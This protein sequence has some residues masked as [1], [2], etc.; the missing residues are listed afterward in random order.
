[1]QASQRAIPCAFMRGGTSRGPFFLAADLPQDIATRDAVLLAVMGSPDPRQIDGLGGSDTLT[2]KVAIVS[3]SSMPGVDVDFLFAQVAVDKPLVDVSPNCGN[4]L[5][6]VGPFAIERGLVAIRGDSTPV[7]IHMVNSGNIATATVQTAG[8]RVVYDGDAR[9]AGVPGTS[10]PIN[11]AFRDT[12]GSAC[13]SLLPTGRTRDVFNGI[14]A[15]CIDNGMPVVVM[16]ADAFGKTGQETPQQLDADAEFKQRLEAVRLQA[17]ELM[18]L[19]DVRNKVVPKMTLISPAVNG[20]HISTRTFIP[21]RCHSAIGVLGAVSVA[22]ACL[23]PGSVAEGMTRL[24]QGADVE[25]SVE[26][27]SG[28]FTVALRTELHTGLHGSEMRFLSSGLLRTARM[29]LD[30]QVYVPHRVWP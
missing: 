11:I 10:A 21:H 15:T 22:S 29:L 28:E 24:P 26:H 30:G 14:E 13:G 2:S 5:A 18:G 3:P 17:G 1:M 23:L 27:P 7:V 9:I 12:A 25:I 6:G 16:R 4:M 8:G 20:G 19:G